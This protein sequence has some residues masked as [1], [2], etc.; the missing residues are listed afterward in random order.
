MSQTDYFVTAFIIKKKKI[1]YQI[2]KPYIVQ[3]TH[4]YI[5]KK[6][7]PKTQKHPHSFISKKSIF[8]QTDK[9]T[10]TQAPIY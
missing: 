8:I 2:Q 6:I 5:Q 7:K 3:Y 1:L 9:H 4:T 10:H